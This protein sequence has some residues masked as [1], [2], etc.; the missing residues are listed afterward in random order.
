M[1]GVLC[2]YEMGDDELS[3][4]GS[5]LENL[6]EDEIQ[7][8]AK[9]DEESQETE[10]DED[11]GKNTNALKENDDGNKENEDD[12]SVVLDSEIEEMLRENKLKQAGDFEKSDSGDDDD[13]S[14]SSGESARSDLELDDVIQSGDDDNSEDTNNISEEGEELNYSALEEEEYDSEAFSF[15]GKPMLLKLGYLQL[16]SIYVLQLARAIFQLS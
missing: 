4:C 9:E 8:E 3:E 1:S 13:D 6:I 14:E 12:A 2:R 16:D 10:S 7:E 15:E 11:D 5:G